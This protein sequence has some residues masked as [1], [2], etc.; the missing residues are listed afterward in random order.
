MKSPAIKSAKFLFLN[1]L[2]IKFLKSLTGR[3]ILIS[4]QSQRDQPHISSSA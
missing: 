1:K 2:E 3:A 4:Q